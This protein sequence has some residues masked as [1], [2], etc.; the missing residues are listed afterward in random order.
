MQYLHKTFL[1]E[2]SIL[3]KKKKKRDM[4]SKR[5]KVARYVDASDYVIRT[6]LTTRAFYS[7]NFLD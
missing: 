2:T 4:Q 1:C 7:I 3:K 5:K 6:C